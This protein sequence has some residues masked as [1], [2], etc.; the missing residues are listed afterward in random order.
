M[1]RAQRRVAKR[2]PAKRKAAGRPK[3][4]LLD[5]ACRER[6]EALAF[7][8]ATDEILG[9]IGR[10]PADTKPVF[11]AIV[12]SAMKIFGGLGFGIALVD[13][14][15]LRNVAEGGNLDRRPIGFRLPLTRESTAGL[16]I[17]RKKVVA[18][19]DVMAAGAPRLA[20][21]HGRAAG[22]RSIAAAPMLRQGKAIG[23]IGVMRRTAGPWSKRHL[24]LLKSF[25]AQA[26]IA[27]ENA[28]LFNETR[29]ALERQTATAEVLKVISGSPTD[30]GPVFQA[31]AQRAAIL[32]GAESAFVTSYDG[33]LVHMRAFYGTRPQGT[34]A[35]RAGYPMEATTGSGAGRAI[36]GARPAQIPDV[37]AD[38]EYAHKEAAR[39]G[40]WRSTL[41]VP[42]VRQGKV[43][44][45]ISVARAQVGTFAGKQV[46]LLQTFADQAVIAIENVRLFNETREALERQTSISEVLTVISSS[47][48]DLAP[49]LD[50]VASRAA[51]LCD[52]TDAR[53][54]LVD[55]REVRHVAGF[56]DL[57]VRTPVFELNP[58]TSVGTAIL[59]GQPV[60]VH[61]IELE[62]DMYPLSREIARK[63][64]WRTT[65]NVPL[66]LSLIHI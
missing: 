58:G 6:D 59:K 34:D 24:D 49:I 53:I 11:D 26:V 54:F 65:L 23:A 33:R 56:G 4:S 31:I 61:D 41:S 62:G 66:M 38:A 57:P 50:A 40:G 12:R 20:R 64:G 28:R 47:P 46:A 48:T 18:V 51:K 22:F 15:G 32:C 45:A 5:L 63:A 21:E 16:A 36:R 39:A 44:G 25:A 52:A 29:E 27:I 3:E 13:E 8:A 35:I 19:A 1:A 30:T 17:L 2:A 60:H 10:S 42:M 55:G 43:V 37:L 14:G 7:Q 9:I